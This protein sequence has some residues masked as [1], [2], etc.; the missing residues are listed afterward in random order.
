MNKE[1]GIPPRPSV[2]LMLLGALL[3]P[4]AE[5][6]AEEEPVEVDF[7]RDIRPILSE[8]CFHCHGPDPETREADL[9]LDREEG[10]HGDLGGYAAVVPGDPGKSELWQ[11][12]H[13]ADE[14]DLMPPPDSKRSLGEEQ[15]Q[16]LRRWI[17]SGGEYEIHWA[18][19]PPERA[20]ADK[21]IDGFIRSGLEERGLGFSPEAS[22]ETLLRRV[23]FDLT[24]LP[25]TPEER[26][27]FLADDSPGAYEKVV[28]RL[29]D[30]PRF[31]EKWARGWLDLARYADSNGF[32]ADQLRDSWAYRDWVIDALN[33]GM[34]FDRFTI[35]QLA[36]DLL[37][38]ATLQ[39]KIATGFHRTVTCNV[40]A[41]VH[42]E[43]NR[44]DQV[45]DR[46]NTTASVW[47]GTTLECAQCHDHKYDPFTME[48]YYG[49]FAFF[50]NTPLEV[51]N[52]NK[53][54]GGVSFD[55]YGP[56]M[57]LPLAE[58]EAERRVR[59]RD[60]LTKQKKK[61][62]R[63]ARSLDGEYSAWLAA[64]E[65]SQRGHSTPPRWRT[66]AIAD[67]SGA[68]GETCAELDD[69]SVL[70]QGDVPDKTTY[71]LA[72]ALP[73]GRVGA[74]RLETLTD[75]SLPSKGP[76]RGNGDRPNA[77]LNEIEIRAGDRAVELV[78]ATADYSQNNWNVSQAID[79]DLKTGWAIAPRFG[80]DHWAVFET[81]PAE[82]G[83][84]EKW[85]FTLTQHYGGG[86]VIGRL[87]LSV[88]ERAPEAED[89]PEEVEAALT[90][91]GGD[92]SKIE[93]RLLREHFE[94]NHPR[95]KAAGK[96]IKKLQRQLDQLSPDT[97]LVMVEMEEGR[98]T[99]IMERGN[100]LSPGEKVSAATPAAL[101]PMDPELP[102]NRLGLAKWLVDPANPLT[103]R[104]V[105]NRWWAE[106]FGHGIVETV[107][108][109]GTQSSPPT[110][111]GLLDWLA[112]ELME[113]GWDQKA[114]LREIVLSRTY[115]Q[116]SR[117]PEDLLRTDPANRAYARGPRFR[118][119]A[120]AIRDN[121]LAVSGLLSTRMGGEPVM[122][123]QPPGQWR[124][125]GRNEPKWVDAT[126]ENRF[127]RGIYVIWRRA[128]P[129][130]SFV[131]FDAPD[132]SSCVVARPRTNTPL[133]ALT[134]LND[135]AYAEAALAL[136]GRILNDR[137]GASTAGQVSYA[138]ER[139]LGRGPSPEE[140]EHCLALLDRKRGEFSRDPAAAK[141]LIAGS[142]GALDLDP[143]LPAPDLAA[144]FHLCN[145]LLNL[146]ET[147]TKG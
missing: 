111:P 96:A 138:F 132:R 97:T 129:Y 24:G 5:T 76:A 98:D 9:R 128:A 130:P 35:E 118:L 90:V 37:P 1:K 34:P 53:N 62:D 135:P 84:G 112:L 109:F 104:V 61:R 44:V 54:G 141:K 28:D 143:G 136:A 139:V 72:A 78:S 8:N 20:D 83:E 133:Q 40:E 110:H 69:G 146:D 36:G 29:L 25:P 123:H 99:R 95:I 107:E 42:P 15:K 116:D 23:S 19:R 14:D 11:R 31:G 33:D 134:L 91:A 50:N 64:A 68:A 43:A 108:D 145:V 94:Q 126:D 137:S 39:Q 81:I 124:Q 89:F 67:F 92:R 127:R 65:E 75:E 101:P 131:N 6:I 38:D 140:S 49:L 7:N 73:A 114:L 80:E 2:P 48:D 88:A 93:K 100:Y 66:L 3:I 71:T 27:A 87:R 22:K 63:L 142:S 77:I 18:Y 45:V 4:F 120:E 57:D 117:I 106:I 17:E 103:A 79:G 121:A 115:R 144:W 13:T 16:L 102:R 122:P 147:V 51:R 113:N 59:L 30:S 58:Q 12:V 41:G 52:R 74:V 55:F 85:T 47:L 125:V 56:T 26:A 82:A 60:A 21:G 70:V 119:S 86:R 46:V 10:A 105:V 32:Q